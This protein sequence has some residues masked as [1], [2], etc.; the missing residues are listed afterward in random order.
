MNVRYFTFC[1]FF[2]L[3]FSVSQAQWTSHIFPHFRHVNDVLL[4]DS[5][6]FI[7]VGGNRSNDAIQTVAY[8]PNR[9]INDWSWNLYS[10]VIAPWL[11]SIAQ[12]NDSVYVAAGDNGNII[13]IVDSLGVPGYSV[14]TITG[15][16]GNADS[17]HFNSVYFVNASVGYIAGGRESQDSIQTIL[18][19]AD[20]GETWSVQ[21]DN[22]GHWLN[23][24]FF[25]DANNGYA[26]GK[27]GTILKT[28]DGGA[29]WNVIPVTGN[30]PN[31]DFK[32]V[33][34]LTSSEGFIVGG[35][36][37]NDSIQ[38]ILKTMDAGE[39]WT[40]VRDTL[41][42]MLNGI[43]FA[44]VAQ[45]YAV[46][47]RGEVLESDDGG[48]TWNSLELPASLTGGLQLNAVDFWDED[49]GVIGGN[50]GK[51]VRCWGRKPAVLTDGIANATT[52]S[53]QLYGRVMARNTAAFAAF[54]YGT[55]P[56]LGTVLAAAPDSVYG[57]DTT[58][59]SGELTSLQPFTYYYYRVKATN[60]KGSSFGA[61]KIFY[62]NA[63][64]LVIT[65]PYAE[66]K[67]AS[68][69]AATSVILNGI[70]VANNGPTA[71][72]FE[73][74]LT[75]ALGSVIQAD[76]VQGA[77]SDTIHVSLPLEG[78]QP[79]K[80]YYY[81]II[82][83]NI[84]GTDTGGTRIF[85][86][87]S[88][89]CLI[90]NCDFEQWGAVSYDYPVG[91]MRMGKTRVVPS[92][93][94]SKAM[95][96]TGIDSSSNTNHNNEGTDGLIIYATKVPD[97]A[98]N[99]FGG[100]GVSATPDSIVFWAKYD[101]VPGD[102]VMGILMFKYQAQLYYFQTVPMVGS[103]AGGWVRVSNP[104]NYNGSQQPDSII[105]AFASMRVSF[106]EDSVPKY[107][108]SILTVDDVQLIGIPETVPNGDFEETASGEWLYPEVWQGSESAAVDE[109]PIDRMQR[110][111]DKAS[112]YFAVRLANDP[113]NSGTSLALERQGDNY[114]SPFFP[115]DWR[116]GKLYFYAKF[117]QGTYG[118]NS[119]DTLRMS[120]QMY[121]DGLQM[122]MASLS[123]DT[124]IN[125][126]TLIGA[127]IF[128]TGFPV[129]S[130]NLPVPDSANIR[131]SVGEVSY[132]VFG[133]NR[134]QGGASVVYIDGISF[135]DPRELLPRD[136]TIIS[137][138]T[139]SHNPLLNMLCKVY[140][141]PAHSSV[142]VEFFN[143]TAGTA[144][145]SIADLQGRVVYQATEQVLQG[146]AKKQIN[147]GNFANGI[148]VVNVQSGFLHIQRKLVIEN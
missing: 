107:S 117:E 27:R 14:R 19:T 50:G 87:R 75:P 42:P 37:T 44:S 85:F 93:N 9:E 58:V 82:A 135:D 66:T 88:G 54:E 106:T 49:Y 13:K 64:G 5:A 134:P 38:T 141:N 68:G 20:G 98:D 30:L 83:Q 10:D 89:D 15:L 114:S 133:D 143:N 108:G 48:D 1:S 129:D 51:I 81:R 90:P 120:L 136:T 40:V 139:E 35:N 16:P 7:G 137:S 103:T 73:Y 39:N 36:K 22:L 78:L 86:T 119:K 99:F 97:G 148:Y 94:G 59:V 102:T 26:V 65:E 70:I 2:S 46:G 4:T 127:D 101:V 33:L 113:V 17:R 12:L 47:D 112:G 100:V 110:T 91:W 122:G 61:T 116:Y 109:S 126:Y 146:M 145:I 105:I 71:V 69:S 41:A 11:K 130:A 121:K 147:S 62:T 23:N 67:A 124:P 18:K 34:F 123:I 45:A 131:F 25:T 140:P 74:G 142:N 92:Y 144:T 128:Y 104:L 52:T 21:R 8:T 56:A 3:V 31:R 32:E 6:G 63:G 72:S 138:I 60:Y 79:D 111:I 76:T 24:I 29:S 28:T 43:D 96:I 77:D 118:T 132:Q 84:A 53:A 55:T 57:E 80:H 125:E 115:V 95:E